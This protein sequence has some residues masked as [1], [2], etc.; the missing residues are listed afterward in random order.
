MTLVVRT[1]LSSGAEVIMKG[2]PPHRDS[3]SVQ[4]GSVVESC[5]VDLTAAREKHKA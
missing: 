1:E 5:L 4:P 3:D 2:P